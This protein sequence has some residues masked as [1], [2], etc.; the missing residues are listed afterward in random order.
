MINFNVEK[1]IGT[2]EIKAD[3]SCERGKSVSLIGES[4]AGKT[5]L[6]RLIAG[7]EKP[8]S[9]FI[10]NSGKFIFHKEKKLNTPTHKRNIS[11]VFQEYTLFPHWNIEKNIIYTARNKNFAYELMDHF[12]ISHLKKRKPAHASGGERQRAALAQ[13]IA[14]EPDLLLLDEPFSSLDPNNRKKACSFLISIRKKIS[15]PVILV[16]HDHSEAAFLGDLIYIMENGKIKEK[17]DME[18]NGKNI[19]SFLGKNSG[20]A[21]LKQKKSIF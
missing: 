4:G 20:A 17:I 12:K 5:T 18:K 7:L 10:E 6:L 8:D 9:G 2:F 11:Y 3:L 1:K 16:T 19:I 21:C 13:A 15:C 14:R